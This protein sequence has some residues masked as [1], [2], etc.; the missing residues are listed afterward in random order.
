MWVWYP[1]M[2]EI[3]QKSM[4]GS[5]ATLSSP[6][7]CS[8][9]DFIEKPPY[10]GFSKADQSFLVVISISKNVVQ[11]DDSSRARDLGMPVEVALMLT[12]HSSILESSVNREL[13]STYV[14]FDGGSAKVVSRLGF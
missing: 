13:N 3:S 14:D 2:T 7:P 8:V 1:P 12:S 9:V 6:T 11:E 4:P 10:F 5:M